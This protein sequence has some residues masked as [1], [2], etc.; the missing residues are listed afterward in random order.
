MNE[1]SFSG[2]ISRVFGQMTA[3]AAGLGMRLVVHLTAAVFAVWGAIGHNFSVWSYV[4]LICL[5]PRRPTLRSSWVLPTAVGA[6]QTGLLLARGM[7]PGIALFFGG[8]QTWLQR[9]I[10]KRGRMGW[11]WA[12]A[13]ALCLGFGSLVQWAPYSEFAAVAA[14]GATVQTLYALFR[15]S[16]AL[17]ARLENLRKSLR[18]RLEEK[19]PPPMEA[20][21]RRLVG[22][23]GA[24]NARQKRP[25]YKEIPLAEAG[26]AVLAG[27]LRLKTRSR[28]EAWD[29]EAGKTFALL[30]KLN[31]DLH[32]RIRALGPQAI[33]D[34]ERDPLERLQALSLELS[35]K[36]DILPHAL[37]ARLDGIYAGVERIL[38]CMRRDPADLAPGSRFLNRYLPAAHRVVDEYA[39]LSAAGA[40]Q[41]PTGLE[42]V[43]ERLEKAFAAE[44][45]RLLQNNA[46]SLDAELKVLD[47][48]LKMDGN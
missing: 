45:S 8:L 2:F 17:R 30:E 6:L 43:L 41:P 27:L 47:S 32:A 12:A 36:R 5:V 14:I 33:P 46:M 10:D 15:L 19:L 29:L 25:G 4:G 40:P 13:P 3:T 21:L 24:F 20:P 37:Q 38:D 9:V 42:E 22:Q 31:D 18:Q 1:D 35:R 48:L 39:R 26:E 16:P 28:P 44:H 34:E 23:L 7:N 11:E